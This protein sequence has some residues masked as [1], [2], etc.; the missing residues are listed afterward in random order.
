MD[1]TVWYM[2]FDVQMF[3]HVSG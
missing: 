1:D 2:Y 3:V